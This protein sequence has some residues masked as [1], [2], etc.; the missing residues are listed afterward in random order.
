M[1]IFLALLLGFFSGVLVNLLADFLPARRHFDLMRT[2]PF[3][4]RDLM[5]PAKFA[6]RRSDGQLWPIYFWSGII[7]EL[8][9]QPVF[10]SRRTVRRLLVEIAMPLLFAGLAWMYGTQRSL[11]FLLF[12]AA[13][14]VLVIVIDVEHRWILPI[15]IWPA[16]LVAVIEA[17]FQP[18]IALDVAIR[19]GLYGFGI[20]L[21]LYVMGIVFD[22]VVGFLRGRHVGRTVLG[23]GDV[24][25]GML[26]GLILGW[27]PLGLALLIMVLGGAVGALVV[28]FNQKRKKRHYRMFSAIPYGPYIALGTA[29]M[30][31]VPWLPTNVLLWLT[32]N[33]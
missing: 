11:P 6:P 25:M 24:R 17:A 14:F 1:I 10:D 31:Y 18:R 15:V 30:L 28:I 19:G 5:L 2:D 12:Y 4:S 33:L 9:H 7:A 8:L 23:W 22:N 20:M 27:H 32:G 26:S 16:A 29:V 3:A 13:V 21:L